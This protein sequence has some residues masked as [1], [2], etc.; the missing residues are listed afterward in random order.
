MPP[1]KGNAVYRTIETDWLPLPEP[2]G[3]R[4]PVGRP[5]SRTPAQSPAG[6]PPLTQTRPPFAS[7]LAR[8]GGSSSANLTNFTEESPPLKRKREETFETWNR[9]LAAKESS[10]YEIN[11]QV[12]AAH[13][14]MQGALAEAKRLLKVADENA[15]EMKRMTD[16][17]VTLLNK[18][19]ADLDA[20]SAKCKSL[21]Q[22]LD[23]LNATIGLPM[24]GHGELRWENF[25]SNKKVA[26]KYIHH[27]TG[28]H[29][30]ELLES[31][32]DV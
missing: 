12:N 11:V 20:A 26:A 24:G 22:E 17:I 21:S 23:D 18:E 14:R 2:D 1:P 19:R 15:L 32:F 16:D 27:L 9:H 10:P 6:S 4:N 3:E 13:V 31:L 30:A 8:P 25:K 28:I 5:K 29:T 7:P